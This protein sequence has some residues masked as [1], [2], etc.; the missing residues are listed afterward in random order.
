MDAGP[1]ERA[2]YAALLNF[3]G[4]V[5]EALN[6]LKYISRSEAPEASLF[7]AFCQM[8]QWDYDGAKESLHQYLATALD[9]YARFVGEVNLASALVVIG[10]IGALDFLNMM[11]ERAQDLG[12]LRLLSNLLELRAQLHLRQGHVGQV[13][14]DL[15]RAAALLSGD[16]SKDLFFVRKW[17][18]ILRAQQSRDVE[19]LRRLQIEARSREEW[20]TVCET[21]L[22]SLKI[23]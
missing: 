5:G 3:S 8:S 13:N 9:P 2:E 23:M 6:I 21:D 17:Q 22:Y 14:L 18:T 11:I 7:C 20:E 16:G 15:D 12:H 4:A 19:P 10:E 1:A